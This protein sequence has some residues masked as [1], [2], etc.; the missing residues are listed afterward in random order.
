[1][2]N[3][4]KF[5]KGHMIA[6]TEHVLYPKASTKNQ[7]SA[8][9]NIF[10][11]IDTKTQGLIEIPIASD[12]ETQIQITHMQGSIALACLIKNT[13]GQDISKQVK[14]IQALFQEYL[15]QLQDLSKFK[16]TVRAEIAIHERLWKYN[17]K[18]SDEKYTDHDFCVT[19]ISGK[20]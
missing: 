8:I 1:M 6:M 20:G 11:S 10:L 19:E 14:A 17:S 2:Q 13:Y 4:S 15:Q 18:P 9:E 5:D 7:G 16:Q 3:V 12:H